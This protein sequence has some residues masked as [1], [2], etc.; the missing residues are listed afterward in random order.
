M[1]NII[2]PFS[3]IMLSFLFSCNRSG[4]YAMLALEESDGYFNSTDEASL[5]GDK[6]DL[7]FERKIIKNGSITFETFNA[8]ETRAL[9]MKGVS[10][11]KGYISSDNIFDYGQR[12][13]HN[14]TIR[15]PSEKFDLLVE[16]LSA[17]A[18]RLDRKEIGATDVTEE[19]IDVEARIKTKKELETRFKELLKQAKS[20]QEILEVEK[21]IGKLRTEIESIEGRFRY[22]KDRVAFSTLNVVF[23]E[24]TS[25]PFGFATKI[26]EGLKSGWTSLLWFLLGLVHIW[27]FV[28]ALAVGGFYFRRHYKNKRK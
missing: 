20:V 1:K 10:E 18:A 11:A 3:I 15:V 16:E 26:G 19:F 21:E 2:L 12:R 25:Q 7:S 24:K 27:P 17:S 22:L 14:I 6:D 4:E 5:D 28:L 13:E 8:K 9:I 23:Y